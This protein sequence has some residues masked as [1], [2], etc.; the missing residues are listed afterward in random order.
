MKTTLEPPDKF[1]VV[2]AQG[3]LELGDH[4]AANDE[5]EK[6]SARLRAHPDV[7][8]VRW[9]IYARAEKWEAS[10]DSAQAIIKLDPNRPDAWIHRSYAFHELG[11]TQAAF[12]Q[13]LPVADNFPK[14]W[15][16]AYNL[17]CY[18][19]RLGRMDE[20]QEWLKRAM[21]IDENAVNSPS[22]NPPAKSQ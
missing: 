18:C 15:T 14:V 21:A 13:L 16:I 12:D 11:R 8:D 9:Q 5:L 4:I 2:A 19:A 17:S 1:Y 20:S 6:V 22:T 10:A 7:L 3:W